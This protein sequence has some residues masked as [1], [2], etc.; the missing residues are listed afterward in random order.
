MMPLVRKAGLS[1]GSM[2]VRKAGLFNGSLPVR[3][4]GLF[5]GLPLVRN[6]GLFIVLLVFF[7]CGRGE[8]IPAGLS[9][10]VTNHEGVTIELTY[11]VEYF[12]NN[13]VVVG[14][15]PAEDNTFL[16]PLYPAQPIA[17][18]L[19]IGRT[20]I[21]MY[22]RPGDAI[23]VSVDALQPLETLVFSGSGGDH[24]NFLLAF[25]RGMEQHAGDRFLAAEAGKRS[26]EGF[27]A[28]LDSLRDVRHAFL[29]AGRQEHGLANDFIEFI[30]T[31]I[32]YD[33]YARLLDYPLLRQRAL[34][35]D[36][37]TTL[38]DG[39]YSFLDDDGLF[40]DSRVE[41]QAY[42]NFLLSYLNHTMRE[43]PGLDDGKSMNE[44]TYVAAGQMLSG[45]S[46][47]YVQAMMVG[48]ELSY[49]MLDDALRLYGDY[50]A[51]QAGEG[52]KKRSESIYEAMQKLTAGNPAPEFTMTDI[53]GREV[54]LGD[55]RGKVIMLDF[56]ASWCPPCLREMPHMKAMKER[57]VGEEDL[58]FVYIS[59]DTDEEAWR[60][61]VDRL[62][63]KGVHFNTPGRERGV[64][65]LYNVKWIPTFYVIG[66]DG[67]I[68]DNRPPMPSSGDLDEVLRQA[69]GAAS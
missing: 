18:G 37:D 47:D 16:L 31:R 12:N 22:I 6:T 4:A 29:Q 14:I 20:E 54:S 21:P 17:A 69:L 56:W 9:G 35:T 60:N 15:E 11:F 44:Q 7:A 26:P 1:I 59:I 45:G 63:L 27:V 25:H 13:R 32:R 58:V 34:G 68:F 49:G 36:D 39:Y 30:D 64:P 48:R 24:N 55:F 43:Q 52:F 28:L 46:R 53:E 57:F 65:P 33:R 19:R 8:K 66:R 61:A 50:M 23:T 42:V 38:P 40:D 2:P 5:N 10:T 51:G 67:N 3:K 62:A 41:H